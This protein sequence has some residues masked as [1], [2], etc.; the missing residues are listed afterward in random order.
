MPAKNNNYRFFSS[1]VVRT[2]VWS[3]QDYSPANLNDALS[4]ETFRDALLVASSSLCEQL[5]KVDFQPEK[6]DAKKILSLNK[7]HNRMHFRPVPFGLFSA[8]STAKWGS[9]DRII[10]GAPVAHFKNSFEKDYKAVEQLKENIG[11]RVLHY[12]ANTTVYK[13]GDEFRYLASFL[14]QEANTLDFQICAIKYLPLV[15][16]LLARCQEKQPFAEIAA[17]AATLGQTSSAEAESLVEELIQFQLLVDDLVPNI[18][19]EDYA[20]RAQALLAEKGCDNGLL[21]SSVP[22][23]WPLSNAGGT[24]KDFVKTSNDAYINLIGPPADGTLNTKYQQPI[25]KALACLQKMGTPFLQTANLKS[26]TTAFEQKFGAR[27]I[28]LLQALDPQ[29]GVGYGNLAQAAEENG[30]L[31]DVSWEEDKPGAVTLNWT[32]VH[33]LILRK[34][35]AGNA[36]NLIDIDDK[37]LQGLDGPDDQLPQPPSISVMFRIAGDKILI[38]NAG[39]ITATSLIGRFTPFDGA[40]RAQAADIVQTETALNPDVLFAEI[41]HVCNLHTANINIRDHVYP[42]EIPILTTSTVGHGHQIPLTDLWVKVM[43]GQLILFSEKHNK[44]VIPRLSSAFSYTRNNLA[45][46]QLL[47]DLQSQHLQGNFRLDLAELLPNL[48]HYPRVEYAGTILYPETW[49]LAVAEFEKSMQLQEAQAHQQFGQVRQKWG[50]TRWISLA[51]HDQQLVF[52]LDAPADVSFFLQCIKGQQNIKIKEFIYTDASDACCINSEGKPLISQFI[53]A[54][55]QDTLT[56]RNVALTPQQSPRVQRRLVPGNEWVFFKIYCHPVQVAQLVGDNIN[57]LAQTLAQK[58]LIDDWFYILYADTGYHIRLRLKVKQGQA[59][60][61]IAFTCSALDKWLKNNLVSNFEIAIYER[62]TERYGGT[63][64]KQFEHIFCRSS[65]LVMHY[66]ELKN[67]TQTLDLP[68]IAFA[69]MRGMMDGAGLCGED[70]INFLE[71][72]N[73]GFSKEF[74]AG[75]GLKVSL[76]QK[77]RQLEQDLDARAASSA[78]GLAHLTTFRSGYMESIAGFYKKNKK[79]A[80]AVL[81]RWLADIIHM[82]LNRLFVEEERKHEF[83]LYSLLLKHER[84]QYMKS[85]QLGGAFTSNRE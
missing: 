4:D 26:F 44:R 27:A 79:Q 23:P 37:D 36:S 41:V 51:V 8:T 52:N 48:P 58:K 47:C 10:A 32:K 54:L 61:T 63:M 17:L 50:L 12:Q 64:V 13:A 2:P 19:G 60:E 22:A 25:L 74:K 84:K 57:R 67:A 39:G 40:I 49:Q 59:G 83:V 16:K 71:Q 5:E 65:S 38:E 70:R 46:F 34:W 35:H 28:P 6:L 31:N 20:G 9:G 80:P 18:S 43:D 29:I 55:Y 45:V 69:D 14:D 24:V 78:Q 81:T 21:S 42:Y 56:Y 30:L 77:Y 73:A 7:Y 15:E 66:F 11:L 33:Q 53:A 75:H 62:E 3:Y 72:V 85:R 82:H 1:L 68:V 76:D